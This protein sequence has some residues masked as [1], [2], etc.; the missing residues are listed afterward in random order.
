MSIV[1]KKSE[2]SETPSSDHLHFIPA[3]INKDSAADV[4]NY[5]DKFIEQS[6][7]GSEILHNALRGRF[8]V[9]QKMDVPAGYQGMVYVERKR[10]LNDDTERVF[11]PKNSFNN[12]TYWNYDKN[13]SRNDAFTQALQWLEISEVLHA[14]EKTDVTK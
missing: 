10:P 14:P 7:E 9:G 12:F 11:Q 8:L 3:R 4:E 13:P 2:I 5:F 1:L 6:A